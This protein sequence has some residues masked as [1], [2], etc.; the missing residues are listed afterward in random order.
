[1]K[2]IKIIQYKVGKK[3]NASGTYI[4]KSGF[5]PPTHQ[6]GML[7]RELAEA[8]AKQFKKKEKD[9][10]AACAKIDAGDKSIQDTR[11]SSTKVTQKCGC[12]IL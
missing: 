8:A 2:E 7:D 12:I 10:Q 11:S 4:K 5:K 3:K 6:P 9:I 1:M